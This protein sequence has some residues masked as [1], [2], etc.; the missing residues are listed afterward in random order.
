MK[1][2]SGFVSNSSSSSFII[3]FNNKYP[4]TLAI[5]ESMIKNRFD[6][7]GKYNKDEGIDVIDDDHP[8]ELQVYRNIKK[9]KKSEYANI[10]MFFRSTNYDTYIKAITDNYAFVDTCNNIRWDIESEATYGIPDE[11]KKQYPELVNEWNELDLA[12]KYN[13]DYY[14]LESGLIA[15][16]PSEY[17]TCKKCYD[18]YWYIDGVKYCVRCDWNKISR[19]LKIKKIQELM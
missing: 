13:E 10:P 8:K 16:S 1:I 12:I 6:E 2:R 5:A 7:W 15:T 9:L 19:G 17:D 4:N 11:L 18:P 14:I 3:R